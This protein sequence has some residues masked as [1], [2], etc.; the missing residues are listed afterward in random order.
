MLFRFFLKVKI[1]LLI[2]LI[3]KEYLSFYAAI[4]LSQCVHLPSVNMLL[5]SLVHYCSFHLLIH[6][7]DIRYITIMVSLLISGSLSL[8]TRVVTVAVTT[9]THWDTRQAGVGSGGVYRSS[10]VRGG[11]PRVVP[12]MMMAAGVR[13]TVVKLRQGMERTNCLNVFLSSPDI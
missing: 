12:R 13:E 1:T 11:R 10:R 5:T 6:H 2:A 8:Y 7:P 9:I 3:L 4:L